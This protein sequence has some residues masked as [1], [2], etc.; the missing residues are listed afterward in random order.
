MIFLVYL[1]SGFFFLALFFIKKG[2]ELLDEK[3]VF[4]SK[5]EVV[6][7]RIDSQEIDALLIEAVKVFQ[8][9][10]QDKHYFSLSDYKDWKRRYSGL[11]KLCQDYLSLDRRYSLLFVRYYDQPKIRSDYNDRFL[12]KKVLLLADSQY[13]E[14]WKKSF[15]YKESSQQIVLQKDFMQSWILEAAKFSYFG[16]Q[17]LTVI[18]NGED[19]VMP[20]KLMEK[21]LV[22]EVNVYDSFE[23]WLMFLTNVHKSQHVSLTKTSSK[24]FYQ[25]E[26]YKLWPS[27]LVYKT[28]Q[29]LRKQKKE[30]VRSL[31]WCK[32][33]GLSPQYWVLPRDQSI[34]KLIEN[35]PVAF[36]SMFA[37]YEQFLRLQEQFDTYHLLQMV[38]QQRESLFLQSPELVIVG[39]ERLEGFYQKWLEGLIQKKPAP[40]LTA[41]SRSPVGSF[42]QSILQLE[43][44]NFCVGRVKPNQDGQVEVNDAL[45]ASD[46]GNLITQTMSQGDAGQ[47]RSD[48]LISQV[49]G[50]Q[51]I[52]I[53]NVTKSWLGHEGQESLVGGGGSGEYFSEDDEVFYDSEAHIKDHDF[54]RRQLVWKDHNSQEES[55]WNSA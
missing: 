40:R 22:K 47:G 50:G 10:V 44:A 35:N 29:D 32:E 39:F 49:L 12:Q 53:E 1:S 6:K 24:L 31:K 26:F 27:S 54:S 3:K 18:R 2:F 38:W 33:C 19:F 21:Y 25:K 48:M 28:P 51:A 55:S 15:F 7:E 13:P 9:F 46:L 36:R 52:E 5:S 42:W 30:F 4:I 41:L 8:G 14:D 11:R 43:S 17:S 20:K 34:P 23:D 16:S 37:F 45:Y